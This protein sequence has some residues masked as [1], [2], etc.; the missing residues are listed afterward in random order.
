[1][2]AI[3]DPSESATVPRVYPFSLLKEKFL[4]KV[5]GVPPENSLR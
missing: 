4:E 2:V 3:P 1:M 5:N